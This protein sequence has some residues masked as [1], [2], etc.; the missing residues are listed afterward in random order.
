MCGSLLSTGPPSVATVSFAGAAILEPAKESALVR[1][2]RL[3]CACGERAG[4]LLHADPGGSVAV[5]DE[6]GT[7]L[8][9]QVDSLAKVVGQSDQGRALPVIPGHHP[10]AGHGDVD[11]LLRSRGVKMRAWVHD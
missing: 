9:G 8:L 11:R 6:C 5:E 2:Y 3:P 4:P 1:A 10:V 7:E